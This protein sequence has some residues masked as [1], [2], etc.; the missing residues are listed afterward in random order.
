MAG[1]FPNT[2]PASG[3][4]P[5]T[6]GFT[7]SQTATDVNNTNDVANYTWKGV[8][9]APAGARVATTGAET[10][11]IVSGSVTVINGTT[12]DG[13]AV[14]VNDVVL[15][16]DAPA[17]SGAGSLGSS[18]PGNG[19]YYV[20]AV[21]T[22]ISV[23]RCATM[24]TTSSQPNPA[25]R[26]VFVRPGGIVNASSMFMVT[27]PSGVAAFTYGTTVMQWTKNLLIPASTSLDGAA[28]LVSIGDQGYGSAQAGNSTSTAGTS[29][30]MF[31]VGVAATNITAVWNHFYTHMSGYP[32]T[33]P[34]G[35]ITINASL[36][37]VSSTNPGT[38]ANVIYRLTFNGRTSVTIDPGGTVT[39]DLLGLS[40]AQGDVVGIRTFL[41]SGTAYAP[42]ATYGLNSSSF[43]GFTSTTDLTAPGSAAITGTNG[44]YYGPGALL[45]YATGA[46]YAKSVLIL[47]DSIA[48][49]TG[50]LP[51]FTVL[52]LSTGGF[53]MRAL[54]GHAGAI[55]IAIPSDSVTFFQTTS[56]SFR[57]LRS[58]QRCNSAIIE[59]G[60]NDIVGSVTAAALEALNLNVATNLR[61]LGIAKVFLTT[62]IPR[63]TSTDGWAT[64]ANQTPLATESVRVA[65]NTW[66]RAG[67]PIDPTTLAAV[68]VGTSGALM[69]GSS[70]HPITNFFD[71][72]AT[73][74]TSLNSGLWL[75]CNRVTTGSMT[76]AAN[77][78]T[79][80][81]ASFV[82]TNQE[83]GGD[84]G[85]S[86]TLMGAGAAGAV[87]GS[88]IGVVSSST[89]ALTTPGAGTTVSGAQLNIGVHTKDGV[90]PST[91][92]HYLM[93]AAI[94]T[95]LL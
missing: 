3:A 35:S 20:T 67:C 74:E 61:R 6:V 24:S 16:K 83:V 54:T 60:S 69:A 7:T 15:V 4:S 77:T 10:Y 46:N 75:P 52:A 94:N 85:T 11:T 44:T 9:S 82:N 57:R 41:S 22:N 21:A 17:S 47:G 13:V 73:V 23:S 19:L 78:L 59:Y 43:G 28:K 68:A 12:I 93:S 45:G 31:T 86:F 37:V 36:R 62:L 72:A 34:G 92:G 56:G 39:A 48:A 29:E 81:G 89:V 84:K 38:N 49:G 33:D 40:L 76:A 79:S 32:D 71:T 26:I 87:L 66:V 14:A 1:S 18:Q 2:P 25:G 65:Y 53:A 70:G 27:S 8:D 50:D 51:V 90:H 80:A 88:D 63:T 55:S 30:I 64:T 95:S 91:H 42:R 58:A 5:L